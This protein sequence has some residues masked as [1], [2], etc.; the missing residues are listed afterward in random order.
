MH[1]LYKYMPLRPEFFDNFLLRA[2]GRFSLNDPFEVLPSV[3]YFADFAKKDIGESRAKQAI[4]AY[5]SGNPAQLYKHYS[6]MLTKHGVISFTEIPDNLLMWAHYA[7]E[8]RGIVIEID[9]EHA[10]FNDEYSF[11]GNLHRVLY[12]KSRLSKFTT[13][14]APYLYKSDEWQYE[15]EHRFIVSL[16]ESTKKMIKK[17]HKEKFP[18]FEGYLVTKFSDDL[19]EISGGDFPGSLATASN[20]TVMHMFSIPPD[21]IKSI[22]LGA[23]VSEDDEKEIVNAIQTNKDLDK[24]K[25]YK[26]QLHTHRFELDIVELKRTD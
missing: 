9:R 2:T 15:K 4:E 7:D 16:A 1:S 21:S 23:L 19:Y 20:S 5:I 14:F 11:S 13:Y 10:F 26:S 24:L 12:R 18:V 3:E 6:G 8:H 22:I 25:I 17:E